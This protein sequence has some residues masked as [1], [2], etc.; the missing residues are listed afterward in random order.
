MVKQHKYHAMSKENWRTKFQDN[1]PYNVQDCL[2]YNHPPEDEEDESPK[3][4][5]PDKLNE[6]SQESSS[7]LN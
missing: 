5:S 7:T 3:L 6:K 1:L 4:N 2:V